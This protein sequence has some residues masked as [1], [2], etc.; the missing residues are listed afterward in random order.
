MQPSATTACHLCRN[1]GVTEL[2]DLGAQPICNRF[3]VAPSDNEFLH[4]MV[5]GLCEACGL[6]QIINPVPAEELMPRVDWITYNEPE[7]RL[8]RLAQTLR[9]LPGIT[10]DTT[11]CGISFKDD[12]TLARLEGL[13]IKRT[14][15]MEPERDLAIGET[16]AGV[17]TIQGRLTPEATGQIS[18]THGRADVVVV[19]HI[20]E[21]AHDTRQYTKAIKQL[22][23][24][25]GYIVFEVPDC[26]KALENCDYSCPWEEHIL[27][28]TPETL[29]RALALS[30][31]PLVSYG[32][33]PYELKDSLVAI[34]RLSRDSQPV[35]PVDPVLGE[36][37]AGA[38][39]YAQVLHQH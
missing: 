1:E 29:K 24:P 9:D 5:I 39:H 30:E 6:V 23:N 34:V 25:K 31:M 20:L 28:F 13:G 17:E 4:P 15:R 12:S 27:Y 3:L 8:D 22:V 7:A 19:R 18:Q 26:T 36:E 21:H 32:S 38:T 35:Q 16:G 2:L 11:I 10:S 14:W 37:R 33:Y